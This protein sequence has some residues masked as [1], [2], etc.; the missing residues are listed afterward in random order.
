[1]SAD[2]LS[3]STR[4]TKRNLLVASVFA[5]AYAAFD[6]T[7]SKIPLAGLE[8]EFDQRLFSFLI[9]SVLVYFTGTF[10]LYYYIDIRNVELTPHQKL[11]EGEYT[12]KKTNY[13]HAYAQWQLRKIAR[14]LPIPV[15]VEAGV[16]VFAATLQKFQSPQFVYDRD[17]QAH[18]ANVISA[19][20]MRRKVSKNRLESYSFVA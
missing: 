15:L 6:V 11:T 8:I 14:R 19:L 16:G 3:S 20:A 2:P 4:T 18:Y 10:I 1:M 17:F 7:I 5:I 13:S 9:L 12:K